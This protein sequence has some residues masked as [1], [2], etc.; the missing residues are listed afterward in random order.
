MDNKKLK[1]IYKIKVKSAPLKFWFGKV[2]YSDSSKEKNTEKQTLYN[3]TYKLRGK[4][5]YIY[6]TFFGKFIPVE[7]KSS[8]INSNLPRENELMQL[9]TYFFLVQENYKKP[10]KG[11]LVYKDKVFIIKNTKAGRK[12]FLS[13]IKDMR[14]IVKTGKGYCE[15]SFV[16][17]K[18]CICRDSVCEF[19]K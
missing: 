7:L 10:Q 2:I 1:K 16:K 15:P 18:Y 12:Y 13:I 8:T 4:P 14:S 9:V 11:Y 3:E 5:D 19:C 17:C 6:K